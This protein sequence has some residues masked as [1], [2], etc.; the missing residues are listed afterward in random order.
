MSLSQFFTSIY[1]RMAGALV[2]SAITAFITVSSDLIFILQTP[3]LFY[4]LIGIELLLV[5]GMQWLI[6]K[7][8]AKI[9][10]LLFVIYAALNGVTMSGF[11]LFFLTNNLTLTITIFLVAAALFAMLALLGYSMKKD[12]SGWGTFLYASVWGVVL[13]S[14]VNI[15]FQNSAFDMIISAVAL[16]LFSALTVYD[17]QYY[18]HVHAQT[19]ASGNADMQQKMA[20]IG[21][22]HMYI[23]F[24]MIFQNLLSISSWFED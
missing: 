20:T 8:S 6:N 7:F 23:N 21:A 2:L 13:S 17:N 4:G 1:L 12:L 24:I 18:K 9:A 10:T 16:I 3:V 5:L 15:Y 19:H 11:L 14:L 22:L